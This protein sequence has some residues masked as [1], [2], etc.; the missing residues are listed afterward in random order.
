[1]YRGLF[2]VLVAAAPTA[3]KAEDRAAPRPAAVKRGEAVNIMWRFDGNG[4]FPN[5]HPPSEWRQ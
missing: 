2:V 4:R 1:M 3:L 5:I